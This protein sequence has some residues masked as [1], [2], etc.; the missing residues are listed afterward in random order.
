MCLAPFDCRFSSPP[1]SLVFPFWLHPL[2][3]FCCFLFFIFYFIF[4]CI[5]RSFRLFRL[6]EKNTAFYLLFGAWH[7]PN[8][9]VLRHRH[10]IAHRACTSPP[11]HSHC[12]LSRGKSTCVGESCLDDLDFL[13]YQLSNTSKR[14]A[15]DITISQINRTTIEIQKK[16]KNKKK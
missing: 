12:S 15:F 16:K 5:C 11:A 7:R 4:I 13:P 10:D 3:L 8:I 2:F 14:R 6:F 9:E 1:T